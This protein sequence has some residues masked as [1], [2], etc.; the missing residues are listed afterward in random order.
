MNFLSNTKFN[1]DGKTKTLF[2][3]ILETR[4]ILSFSNKIEIQINTSFPYPTPKTLTK[5]Q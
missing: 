4:I 1:F 3:G 2:I 5:N